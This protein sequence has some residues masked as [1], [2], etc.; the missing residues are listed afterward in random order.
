MIVRSNLLE[1]STKEPEL[2]EVIAHEIAHDELHA[3]LLAQRPLPFG[4]IDSRRFVPAFLT[5]SSSSS[6]AHEREAIYLGALLLV[7]VREMMLELAPVAQAFQSNIGGC[8]G[9]AAL[10]TLIKRYREAA[11][12][13]IVDKF[14]VPSRVA[15]IALDYWGASSRPCPEWLSARPLSRSATGIKVINKV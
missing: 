8:Y 4:R 6:N 2:L 13:A 5:F 15:K 11:V 12:S 14:A 3:V 7:P 10:E 1:D 9:D